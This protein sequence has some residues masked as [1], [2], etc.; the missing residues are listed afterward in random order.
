MNDNSWLHLTTQDPAWTLPTDLASVDRFGARDCGWVEQ[1]QP[2]IAHLC[3]PEGRVL[4]P[5][6]GFGST[7]VAAHSQGRAGIG[8]EVDGS[9]VAL[10]RQRLQR[11]SPEAAEPA[12]QL[13]HGDAITL[14]PQLP[15]V[16]L[17]LSNVPYFGCRW[18]EQATA[19]QPG[20]LY[21][22]QTYAGFLGM[23]ERLLA[24][25]RCCLRPGG[26]LVLCAENLR[27]GEHFVPLAWDLARLMAD[28][29]SFVEERILLYD[30][31]SQPAAPG[32][33]R[34]NR[35]HEY[36]LL[37]RHLPPPI[38]TAQTLA[39]LQAMQS[40]HPGFVVYGSF[41][42]WLQGL[43][44]A[45]APADADLLLPDDPQLLVA[46]CHWLE[47]QGFA[48]TC[49]GAPFSAAMAAAGA[50]LLP[51]RHYLRAVR[52]DRDGRLVRLDLCLRDQRHD[53]AQLLP[54]AVMQAGL[55]LMPAELV[56]DAS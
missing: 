4:D 56:Q 7:L 50:A 31:A 36:A 34:S 9:R 23:L 13:I 29:F 38:D 26:W 55:P 54:Q 21:A 37:A 44:L 40:A 25:L 30:R 1:M 28:R 12:Q 49:W 53:A 46:L 51:Q 19:A 52:L 2:F 42:R 32:Q 43:P 35:A 6:C 24:G 45:H 14:L 18:P 17:V 20:Q 33:M 39:V 27:V 15:P 3:P 47:Q 16:D 41:A 5:F 22:S 11:L 48:L 8:I 10:T